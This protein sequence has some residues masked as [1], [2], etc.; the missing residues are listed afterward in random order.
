[1]TLTWQVTPNI[2][3]TRMLG[4]T[5]YFNFGTHLIMEVH[6]KKWQTVPTVALKFRI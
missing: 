4:L 3:Y 5:H 2:Q 6:I 1:M